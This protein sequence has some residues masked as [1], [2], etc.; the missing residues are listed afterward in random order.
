M[1]S[2]KSKTSKEGAYE[3][4]IH[5]SDIWKRSEVGPRHARQLRS[6][7]EGML[8]RRESSREPGGGGG[9]S[10]SERGAL[11]KEIGA[12]CRDRTGTLRPT[13]EHSRCYC[14]C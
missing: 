6:S 13:S 7:R 5:K 14:L 9:E 3:I 2:F 8:G 1:T 12:T 10:C 11:L 4:D